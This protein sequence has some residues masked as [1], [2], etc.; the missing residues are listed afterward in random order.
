MIRPTDLKVLPRR[1]I[2]HCVVG[3]GLLGEGGL[4]GGFGGLAFCV[5]GGGW[6]EKFELL[7]EVAD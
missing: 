5:G 7:G 4:A 3:F 1:L 2:D 6:Q